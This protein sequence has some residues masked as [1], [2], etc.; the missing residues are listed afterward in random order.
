[1]KNERLMDVIGTV[2]PAFVAEAA[3]GNVPAKAKRP[4]RP[5]RLLIAAAIIIAT[6]MVSILGMTISAE[7]QTQLQ[8]VPIIILREDF[9]RLIVE[10]IEEIEANEN[11]PHHVKMDHMRLKAFYEYQ[12]LS[13][14]TSSRHREAMLER[15]PIT[16]LGDVCTLD[17]TATDVDKKFVLDALRSLGF[18]QLDL[19]ECYERMYALAEESDSENKEKILASLPAIPERP[20]QDE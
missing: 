4:I 19:I 16:E 7:E 17:V 11:T 2:S 12:F 1:M 5:M 8:E 9:D 3:P 18:T 13:E 15:F 20:D 10:K 14:T 6:F